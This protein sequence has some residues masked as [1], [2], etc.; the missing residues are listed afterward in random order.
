M[1]TNTPYIELGRLL[2]SKKGK[3]MVVERLGGHGRSIGDY[4]LIDVSKGE[5][6]EQSNNI[7]SFRDY[8][9]DIKSIKRL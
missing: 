5:L 2:E 8:I 1:K 9:G 3:F 4:Y 6:V 7:N